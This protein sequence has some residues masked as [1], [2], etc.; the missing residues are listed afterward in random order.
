MTNKHFNVLQTSDPDEHGP[1]P[2]L[3][4]VT[5]PRD[6][7]GDHTRHQSVSS[8]SFVNLRD[9]MRKVMTTIVSKRG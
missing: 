5:L 8:T 9:E 2:V 1:A 4:S 7:V 3:E 6:T